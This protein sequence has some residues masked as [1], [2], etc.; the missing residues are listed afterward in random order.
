D[1]RG[2]IHEND[3][4]ALQGLKTYVD[5][6]FSID[7]SDGATIVA[8][9]IRGGSKNFEGNN[10]FDK[11]EETYW[12]TDDNVTQASL[13]VDFG[14]EIEVN[15]LLLQ[16]YIR[17][18]QRIKGF[19]IEVLKDAKYIEVAKGITI[20]NRRL[21]KFKTIKTQKLRITFNGKACPVIS[22]IE[23]YRVPEMIGKPIIRRNKSGEVRIFSDSPDPIYYYTTDGSEPGRNSIKYSTPFIFDNPGEIKAKAFLDSGDSSSETVTVEFDVPKTKWTLTSSSKSHGWY[24]IEN[25]IDGNPESTWF[26]EK[27]KETKSPLTMTLDLGELLTVSG[28]TYLPRQDG[29][30]EGNIFKYQVE[31]SKDGK[32]WTTV[33]K[34]REFSNIGNN[35][36]LQKVMF[37][38]PFTAK[39]LRLTCIDDVHT[40]GWVNVAELGVLTR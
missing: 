11:D 10:A 37:S 22:N 39:F 3:I 14:K 26:T 40:E 23:V 20:G 9:N 2:L 6:A 29:R 15:C 36:V 19:T 13:E 18:G 17:L 21:I 16:E 7:Y 38:K 33:L 34:D 32:Q 4:K 25:A 5:N 8:S 35:P 24:P 31:V 12:A 28:F 30:N 27:N 1:K